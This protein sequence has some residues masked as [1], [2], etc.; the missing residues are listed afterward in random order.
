MSSLAICVVKEF[1]LHFNVYKNQAD[2][3]CLAKQNKLTNKHWGL[4]VP[5]SENI[6]NLFLLA[7][8]RD[9]VTPVYPPD[10][11]FCHVFPPGHSV[12]VVISITLCDLEV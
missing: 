11:H 8:T 2:P 12:C 6:N 1:T 9:I 7:I 3:H 4:G 5:P 10:P